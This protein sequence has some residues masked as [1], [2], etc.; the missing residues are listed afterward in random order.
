MFLILEIIS[1]KGEKEWKIAPKRWVC[2]SKTTQR[3]VLF[4]PDEFN[5]ERQNQLAIEGTCKPL[6]SWRRKECVIRQECPTYEKAND[7]L[8]ALLVQH[9]N[10][11]K[12]EPE[13]PLNIEDPA[14]ESSEPPCASISAPNDDASTLVTQIKSML[15]SLLKK[16]TWIEEQSVN[17]MM[18]NSRIAN[19]MCLLQKRVRTMEQ[20]VVQMASKKFEPME[21]VEQLRQLNEKLNDESFNAE[22]VQFLLANVEDDHM[23]WR[24]KSCLDLLCSLEMQ[25]KLRWSRGAGSIHK[26]AVQELSNVIKLFEVVGQTKSEDVSYTKLVDFFV[27]HLKNSNTRFAFTQKQRLKRLKKKSKS[28]LSPD[29]SCEKP[30]ETIR[31]HSF[32]EK[33]SFQPMKTTWQLQE[34]ENKLNDESFHAELV[35]W[36]LSNVNEDN[37]ILRM[38]RCVNLLCSLELQLKI[39]MVWVLELKTFFNLLMEVGKTSSELV[40][41]SSAADFLKKH[42]SSLKRKRSL[43]KKMGKRTFK[44]VESAEQ[45]RELEMKLNDESFNAELLE[46]LLCN[47]KDKNTNWRIKSC[48][49]LLCSIELQ[50]KLRWSRIHGSIL[51]EPINELP[52]FLD[53]FKVV[54][55]TPSEDVTH[56]VL[57][58]CFKSHLHNSHSRFLRSLK[59]C[60][61]RASK[62]R[63]RKRGKSINGVVSENVD[64]SNATKEK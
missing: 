44:P 6:Q 52:N 54:G 9:S 51:K 7:E 4:W 11:I 28:I 55:K 45:L 34:L 35:Q 62:W 56:S 49:D 31:Q 37:T 1:D 24:L 8:Q 13:D 48:L 42:L 29:K 33:F 15:E 25:T 50:S 3:P 40:T 19:E 12:E 53:L 17:I 20:T 21:T 36:L 18:Q 57:A 60:P 64:S 46:W 39:N 43:E 61:K 63:V 41:F 38:E 23:L 26:T 22:L 58:K 14:V 59:D 27:L 47:V 10:Q 32:E 5:V 2:T 16:N 30:E